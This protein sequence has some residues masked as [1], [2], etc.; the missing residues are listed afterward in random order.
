MLM[1]TGAESDTQ[2][3][4]ETVRGGEERVQEGKARVAE[5]FEALGNL[6]PGVLSWTQ[7]VKRKKGKWTLIAGRLKFWGD[8]SQERLGWL[9]RIRNHWV[10][11]WAG[12]GAIGFGRLDQQTGGGTCHSLTK[13]LHLRKEK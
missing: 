2:S 6:F 5:D 13:E 1:G 4:F 10:G 12:W 11:H 9:F 7:W 8:Y 3:H